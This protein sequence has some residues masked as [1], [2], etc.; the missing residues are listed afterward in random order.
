MKILIVSM[1]SIHTIRWVNQLK[2]SGH[3]VF[4]FDI[5]KKYAK[6]GFS[7]KQLNEIK[8]MIN[9]QNLIGIQTNDDY[10]NFYSVPI[11]QGLGIDYQYEA[12]KFIDE[13]SAKDFNA[14]LREF[15][16]GDWNIIKVGRS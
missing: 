14:F 9:G 10:A 16:D 13:I 15:L 2:D 6:K 11:L 12:F 4:Y 5:L 8:K 7:Q 1:R 3:E